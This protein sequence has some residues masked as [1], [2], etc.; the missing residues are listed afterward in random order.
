M[1]TRKIA[2]FVLLIFLIAACNSNSGK[3]NVSGNGDKSSAGN[4]EIVFREYEHDFG[5]VMEGEKVAYVFSFENKGTG[6]LVINSASTSCGCT[7]SKYDTRPI[8]PGAQ[9]TLEV[10]FNT[11]GRSGIQTKTVSVNSNSGTPVVILKIKA[12]V[13]QNNKK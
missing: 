11:S 1:R 13:I 9:G 5:K 12:E 7:V 4:P 3:N 6:S 10:V 8:L 2:S